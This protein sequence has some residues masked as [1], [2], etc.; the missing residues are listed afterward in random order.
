MQ[1]TKKPNTHIKIDKNKLFVILRKEIGFQRMRSYFR[2]LKLTVTNLLEG[3]LQG[4]I[5]TGS[6][7]A[8]EPV[9]KFPTTPKKPR[10]Q[11][12]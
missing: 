7:G 5:E 9:C 8:C 3:V 6:L 11:P 4:R 10:S 12:S 1:P 2:I